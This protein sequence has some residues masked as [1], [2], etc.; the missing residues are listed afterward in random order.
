MEGCGAATPNSSMT[1][2]QALDIVLHEGYNSFSGT[3]FVKGMKPVSSY[4][5]FDEL[6]EA[7]SDVLRPACEE[8]AYYQKLNYQLAGE[9]A[10]YLHISLLT[11]D[12]VE[13]GKPAFAG[14]CRYL[15][16]TDEVFGF[17]TCADSL[18]AIKKCV[19]EDKL[20]TLEEL[21]KMLDANFEGYEKEREAL[22][23]APKYGN[24]DDYA[25]EIAVRV[26][27]N[28]SEL[29]EEAGRKFDLPERYN[30]VSVNNS[31]SAER[32]AACSA[33]PC[34]RKRSEPLSNGNSPSIGGDKNGL[35][36]TLNSM[37]KIDPVRHVG[38]VHN[39]RFNK[40]ML[41]NNFDTI[42][43]LLET[44]YENGGAQTNLSSIGKDDLEQAMIHPERYRNLLVRIGGFSARFV[45]LDP[46]VQH[47][48]LLRTTVEEC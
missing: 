41:H 27:N 33:T 42:K 38:V 9:E 5:T 13:L 39:I 46:I 4:K 14:G 3:L 23:S 30:I 19:Y 48:L 20:F 47:E 25:D 8:T 34:G 28:I 36:A 11:H 45:E 29:H 1:L 40:D 22:L 17:V 26:F 44:F 37:R 16:E 35:T 15:S 12:S 32:G 18:T 7:Y 31:G 43:M 6:F 2:S 21:V 24:D 10:A